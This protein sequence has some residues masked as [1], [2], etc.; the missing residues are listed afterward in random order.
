MS[1]KEQWQSE[2]CDINLPLDFYEKEEI[3]TKMLLKYSKTHN[4]TALKTKDEVYKNIIDSI[5]PI[6]FLN[7]DVTKMADIGSGAGFPGIH[8]ALSLKEC[9]VYL[10]EP[11]AKK[12]S[13]LHWVK[14]ELKLK[15]VTIKSTRIENEKDIIFDFIVS[16]AVTQTKDLLGLCKNISDKDT[17]FLFY[18]G[19]NVKEELDK[20]QNYN[21]HV[22][23]DRHYLFLRECNW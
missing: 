16:R 7:F 2:I 18:K 9:E 11:I 10:Y 3:Y 5:Y 15:N 13:F 17:H 23:D 1:L 19:S 12:S 6:K 22:K 14:A 8:L 20:M 4:I 21:L